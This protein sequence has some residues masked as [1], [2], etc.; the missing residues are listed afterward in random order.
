[1]IKAVILSGGADSGLLPLTINTP[2]SL[3]PIGNYPL[4]LFQ[5]HQL[6]RAGVTEIILSLP[7]EPRKIR[8]VFDDGSDFGVIIRYH[9][10]STPLGT[11]GAF[12]R[13]EHLIDDTA[14]V[15]NGDIVT[16][17]SFEKALAI[18]RSNNAVATISICE[19]P[20]P[21]SYGVVETG[22]DG[23]VTRFLE[24][25]RGQQ[26]RT[27]MVNAGVYILEPEVLNWIPEGR[28]FFFERDLFQLF[29]KKAVPFFAASFSE[30]WTEITRPH[31]YWQS[32]MDFLDHKLTTPEFL[33]FAKRHHPPD[34]PMVTADSSSFI[35]HDCLLKA[36]TRIEHSVIGSNCRIEEGA[37][38]RRSVIWPGCR[39]QR[40]AVVNGSILG[41]GC[42]IGDGVRIRA[43]N[44]I[45]DRSTL[46]SESR[47]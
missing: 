36:G 47:T 24:R 6:K 19:V 13:A 39:I 29:L 25:P 18:H 33:A 5:I 20:R 28:Q 9:V 41:R 31:N 42:L 23:R 22:Q 44:L 4:L 46:T 16:E 27:N 3:L 37:L 26:F 43:G 11:A 8:D 12:K 17:F 1:M 32:N 34:N 2:K 7:H 45:G 35:D 21:R 38:I 30:Y 40:G 15:V 10:E 14:V